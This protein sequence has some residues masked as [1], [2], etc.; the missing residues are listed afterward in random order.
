[1]QLFHKLHRNQCTSLQFSSHSHSFQKYP[2]SAFSSLSSDRIHTSA[3]NVFL[4]SVVAQP[5][6]SEFQ[7]LAFYIIV[8]KA[9]DRRKTFFYLQK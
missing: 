1:M 8:K 5:L 3:K 6:R 4:L 2:L 7:S 9:G